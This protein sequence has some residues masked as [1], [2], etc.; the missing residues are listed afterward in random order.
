VPRPTDITTQRAPADAP[1][2]AEAR[3]QRLA[4]AAP[5]TLTEAT[6][7]EPGPETRDPSQPPPLVG[8]LNDGFDDYL[9]AETSRPAEPLT[10]GSPFGAGANFVPRPAETPRSFMLRVAADLERAPGAGPEV[11]K[12]I[13]RIR[14]GE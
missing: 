3:L 11:Q 12:L 2:G 1:F 7:P 10:H 9:F 14:A 6:P 4:Q 5:T 13:A 8:D